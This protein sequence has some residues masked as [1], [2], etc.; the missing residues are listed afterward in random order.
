MQENGQRIRSLLLV[1]AGG[2]I[3]GVDDV[4]PAKWPLVCEL[5][6]VIA[7]MIISAE[8]SLQRASAKA[9]QEDEGKNLH[10]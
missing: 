3:Q 8:L 9:R 5:L 10:W 4:I 2:Q 6:L 1:V 7:L